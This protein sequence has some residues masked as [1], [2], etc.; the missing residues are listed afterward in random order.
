VSNQDKAG[1][2]ITV[3]ASTLFCSVLFAILYWNYPFDGMV[4]SDSWYWYLYDEGDFRW[5]GRV[6]VEGEVQPQPYSPS[7]SALMNRRGV[8]PILVMAIDHLVV[9]DK[10]VF[11][12]VL[13]ILVLGANVGLFGYVVWQLA[14]VRL[15]FPSLLV[16][17]LYPFASGSHFWQHLV[18]NN[19]AV[20]FFLLSLA[21][22]LRVRP[23]STFSAGQAVMATL[24]LLCYWLS[25]LVLCITT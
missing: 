22:F 3:A 20:T 17:A 25:I 7:W 13:C 5:P 24:S 9:G 4:L 1:T 2:R 19:L 11:L 15:L 21:L 18:L 12:N 8:M 6:N 16:T 23:L 14:G 10:R